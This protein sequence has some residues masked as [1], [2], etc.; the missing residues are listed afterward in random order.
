MA[1]LTQPQGYYRFFPTT[2]NSPYS[3]GGIAVRGYEVVHA[4]LR[5]ALPW[6]DGLA[7]VEK[8]LASLGRPRQ[9]LCGVELRCAEPYV[10]NQWM[11]SGTF[12][13]EYLSVLENWNLFV[14]G[15]VPVGR[16]NVAPG[17]NPP[18]E[19]VLH[20]FSYTVPASGSSDRPTFVVAGA[21][22]PPSVRAGE[23]SEDA[24]REKT[25]AAMEI[26]RERLYGL[27]ATWDDVTDVGVYTIH[28]ILPFLVGEI[29]AK[30][31]PAA[32]S[33]VNWVY[34]RPPITDREVEID[35]RGVRQDLRL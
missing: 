32:R 10:P 24:L 27:G 7:F 3:S 14:D 34:S 12:N 22:E 11:G 30:V 31:R 29:L 25:A 19:Q 16:T 2:T 18:S 13:Q 33:G 6:R 4:T 21:A 15:L 35:L 23:T 28:D 26:M 5:T 20:G 8:H 1:L 17:V 9:A